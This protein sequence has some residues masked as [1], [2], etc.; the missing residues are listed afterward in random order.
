[1][2]GVFSINGVVFMFKKSTVIA[3]SLCGVV[4][5]ASAGFYNTA[6][7]AENI[8]EAAALHRNAQQGYSLVASYQEKNPTIPKLVFYPKGAGVSQL[9]GEEKVVA[10][11]KGE[12]NKL[13][14]KH[15]LS[16]LKLEKIQTSLLGKH[17]VYQQYLGKEIVKYAKVI[18]TLS[19]DG[20]KIIKVFNSAEPIRATSS[21][22]AKL[23][24][25]VALN[26]AWNY[27]QVKGKL[28]NQPKVD[29]IYKV[30]DK[31]PVLI[32][33]VMLNVSEPYGT[34]RHEIDAVTGK[35][36]AVENT[37]LNRIYTLEHAEEAVLR[38]NWASPAKP[39]TL[40][41]AGKDLVQEKN[42]D[43]AV[44]ASGYA[45]VFDP[46]P[47]T[48]LH[49]EGLTDST[50]SEEF[51]AA[52][53]L[54]LLQ[55]ISFSGGKYHLKG[56]WVTIK[57]FD[58]PTGAP[59]TSSDGYWLFER[60]D[61]AFNDAMSYHHVDKSQ[62][63]I[64]SLGFVAEK[65]IQNTSISVDANGASGQDN[66]FYSSGE[67]QM[68]FG[69]GCVDDNEDA[70]VI[71]HE[72]GHAIQHWINDDW[73]GG[74][75]GAMG[76]GFGD[77]WAASHSLS[78]VNGI[79][80]QPFQVFNWDAES[81]CWPGR[82]L[83]KL[84]ARYNHRTSYTAHSNMNG[85]VSDE[86]W[87]TPLF[88]ALYEMVR[89]GYPREDVDKIVLESHFGLGHGVKMRDLAQNTVV[90]AQELF[91]DKPY[92][93]IFEKH[94]VRHNILIDPLVVVESVLSDAGENGVPDPGERFKLALKLKNQGSAVMTSVKGM[95][96]SKAVD[97]DVEVAETLWTDM[98]ATEERL[99]EIPFVIAVN[100]N[101]TCGVNLP[102]TVNLEYGE[103]PKR[104]KSQELQLTV[105]KPNL[106][107]KLVTPDLAIPDRNREGIS[108]KLLLEVDETI[109]VGP[110]FKVKMDIPHVE[111]ADLMVTLTAP[112]G[113]K[114]ILWKRGRN[115][116]GLTGTFPTTLEAY[117]SLEKLYGVPMRGEWTLTVADLYAQDK[118]TLKSWGIESVAGY[119]CEEIGTDP[120]PVEDDSDPSPI[121]PPV[122][123][124]ELH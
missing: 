62:R 32:Y 25:D 85:F 7:A 54:G 21:G 122:E 96:M 13:G 78:T 10:F 76:E 93:S 105:G 68:S 4:G 60:G 103:D 29:L 97:A 40:K 95:L 50:S 20:E 83:D 109:K 5:H 89:L 77:Y 61:T 72:Y 57:D 51:S 37:H 2:G 98:R 36:Y 117:E 33:E 35:I 15:D 48:V 124:D 63:Y 94:F 111:S 17:Y 27:L 3:L 104:F 118:G 16:N 64:Q 38:D 24:Q 81:N 121:E 46:D 52:Y 73:A 70:D 23:S 84:D 120:E 102:F 34:W 67:N 42:N 74:D 56:P 119:V 100:A 123:G 59:S 115:E 9:K 58:P 79:H 18:V 116:G 43:A 31:E 90:V 82:R 106:T 86:L 1:M 45:S 107:E 75:T 11:L 49:H 71:L 92:A 113:E 30:Y 39:I 101:A 87:S 55:D 99:Q 8:Q 12:A 88:Q 14:L 47:M 44:T 53:V 108:S 6:G 26:L 19:A 41:E 22:S 112:S 80:F 28:L 91:P 110:N 65:G 66:S 114:V 69:H